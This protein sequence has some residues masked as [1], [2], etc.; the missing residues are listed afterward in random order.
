MRLSRLPLVLLAGALLAGL[1]S[2]AS[3]I[4][5]TGTLA[6]DV[7]T[8][9]ATPL[10]TGAPQTTDSPTPDPTT[11]SPTPDEPTETT[12]AVVVK[13]RLLCVLERSA[14][15]TINSQFNKSADRD[16][17]IK[18]LQRGATTIQGHINRSGLPHNDGVRRTGQAVLDQLSRLIRDATGGNTPSTQPYNVAT[19]S[20]QKVCNTVS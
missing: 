18:I 12:S 16:A 20:F 8:G 10:P 15:T 17:Q 19:Q 14:I 2:C 11:D 5:G 1:V 4:D 7:A 6:A 9:T 13:E 3:T